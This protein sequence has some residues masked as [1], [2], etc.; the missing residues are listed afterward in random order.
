MLLFAI[1]LNAN[2]YSEIHKHIKIFVK[3]ET[4]H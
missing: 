4:V 1:S 2:H 3:P